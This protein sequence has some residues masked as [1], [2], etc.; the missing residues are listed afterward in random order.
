[1]SSSGREPD[2]ATGVPWNRHGLDRTVDEICDRYESV[3]TI[4]DA[5]RIEDWIAGAVGRLRDQLTRELVLADLE[6]HRRH[7]G[8]VKP[9]RYESLYDEYPSWLKD[10]LD[11]TRPGAL[12]PTIV[13]SSPQRQSRADGDSAGNRCDEDRVDPLVGAKLA[14]YEIVRRIARGGMGVVYEARDH[15]LDRTVAL[16]TIVGGAL[17]SLEAVRRFQ[18]EAQAAARIE[19]PGIVP[20]HDVSSQNEIHYYVM[21]LVEGESLQAKMDSESFSMMAAVSLIERIAR[22][23]AH[24]HRG[25]VVHRDLK[26]ANVLI[27]ED[28]QPRITDFGLAKRMDSDINLTMAGQILGTPGY[29]APEQASGAVD[30]GEA[31]D[32]YSIGAILYALLTGKPPFSAENYMETLQL[33]QSESPKSPRESR[34]EIPR[35]L[36]TVCLKCLAKLP[37]ARYESAE[38]LADDLRRVINGER[39]LARPWSIWT[40]LGIGIRRRPALAVTF[41]A[42]VPLYAWHLYRWWTDSPFWTVRNHNVVSAIVLTWLGVSSLFQQKLLHAKSREAIIFAWA[43]FELLMLTIFLG[44]FDGPRS[45]YVMGYL[46]LVAAAALRQNRQL[47]VLVT[48][49]SVICYAGLVVEASLRRPHKLPEHVDHCVMMLVSMLVIGLSQWFMLRRSGASS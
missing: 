43:A 26:P 46:L 6:L 11:A 49:G 4:E 38:A 42:L 15:K 10:A 47:V 39:V 45:G 23:V 29:M 40:R 3:W 20:I 41:L 34:R 14:N 7:A 27:D 18:A 2:E 21:G 33:V 30:V 17:A 48:A 12:Q 16:K 9:H 1:M 19:H 5:P 25:G 24:A 44:Y 35:D 28:G 13:S 36:E 8:T 37:T 22:A 32:I 31:A